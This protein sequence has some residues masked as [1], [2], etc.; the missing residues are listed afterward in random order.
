[1]V[2]EVFVNKKPFP[3]G[4]K[5]ETVIISSTNGPG[6]LGWDGD[7]QVEQ[8]PCGKPAPNRA[9]AAQGIVRHS[10]S[11]RRMQHR[12]G[13]APDASNRIISGSWRHR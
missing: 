2:E 5:Y 1:V 12:W 8:I 4:G 10:D 13:G 7:V 6:E 3:K 9:G 11:I